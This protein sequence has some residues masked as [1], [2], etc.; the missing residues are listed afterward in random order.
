VTAARASRHTGFVIL[1]LSAA[2]SGCG[3]NGDSGSGASTTTPSVSKGASEN[4]TTL[5]AWAAGLCQGIASWEQTVKT[6]SAQLDASQADFASASQAINSTN[7]AL[8]ASLEGLGTPPAPA[9]ADA[10]DVIDELS[11]NLKNGAGE[12]QQTLNGTFSSQSEIDSAS[13][14]VRA[15]TKQMKADISKAVTELR[16]LPEQQGWKKSFRKAPACQIVAKG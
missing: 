15:S 11:T 1:L 5:D 8:I 10:N 7:Q 6:T 2:L 13:A 3:S 9:T 14:K 12:I 16:A 4:A